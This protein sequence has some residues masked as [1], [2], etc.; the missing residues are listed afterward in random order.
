ML[1]GGQEEFNSG[2]LIEIL[3]DAGAEKG[4]DPLENIV[5]LDG[6]PH[7]DHPVAPT[8][9]IHEAGP[10]NGIARPHDIEGID[11]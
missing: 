1:G 4:V 9:L 2:K 3:V 7:L 6:S 8:A 11:Q 10:A 5:P